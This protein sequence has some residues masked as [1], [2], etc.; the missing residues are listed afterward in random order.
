MTDLISFAP[1]RLL[2]TERKLGPDM[3][4]KIQSVSSWGLGFELMSGKQISQ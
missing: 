4:A 2:P 3:D 1:R